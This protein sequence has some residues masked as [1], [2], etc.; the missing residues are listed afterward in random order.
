MTD[1]CNVLSGVLMYT[2][3]FLAI[4]VFLDQLPLGIRGKRPLFLL[5]GYSLNN[6]LWDVGV[7]DPGL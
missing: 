7:S 6:S 4:K 5:S 2:P 1:P 3:H